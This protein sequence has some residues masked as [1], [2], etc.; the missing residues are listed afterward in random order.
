MTGTTFEDCNCTAFRLNAGDWSYTMIQELDLHGVE[1]ADINFDIAAVYGL[2]RAKTGDIIGR[3]PLD[4]SCQLA[5][6]LLQVQ[7]FPEKDEQLPELTAALRELSEEDPLL[8]LLWLPEERELHLKITGVIQ[9]E[10]LSEL[11]RDRYGMTPVFSKPS[12]I[13]KETPAHEGI[14]FEAYTMP[15]PCWAVVKLAIEPLPRGSGI[16]YSSAIKENQLLYQYGR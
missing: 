7:V 6:P 5:V 4:R 2:S 15:K 3:Q 9:L 13:Y 14:G 10:I 1:L 11:I 16:V 8:D 12:V